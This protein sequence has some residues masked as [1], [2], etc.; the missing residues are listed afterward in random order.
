MSKTIII[1]LTLGGR[2]IGPFTITDDFG[3]IIAIGVPKDS[4][5][6][7]ISYVV[8]DNVTNLTI[9]STGLCTGSKTININRAIIP[10]EIANS[11]FT[12][13]DVSSLWR[14]LAT[15]ESFNKYYGGIFPYVIEFPFSYAPQDQILQSIKSYDKVY[16]Y[17]PDSTGVFNYN[18]KIE[19]NDVYFTKAIIYNNQQSTGVLELVPKPKHNL[20]LY[21]SYPIYRES[22]KV[23]LFTKSDNFY[24]INN[25]TDVV[26][27]KSVQL[28]STDCNTL[29]VDKVVNQ[30]NMDYTRRSF[31]KSLLRAKD[32]RVRFIY[33]N[34]THHL[35]S[36]FILESTQLSYK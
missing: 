14:H 7:G 24:Q 22:S 35:V 11:N 10:I 3:N 27:D 26:K 36:Q 28:F 25:F 4:L 17:L 34:S 13:N 19:V 15:P 23:I 8:E 2:R 31:N 12:E 16:K 32:S 18:D 1:K 30:A 6:N 21:N 9:S 5:I 33:E 29:S 20:K